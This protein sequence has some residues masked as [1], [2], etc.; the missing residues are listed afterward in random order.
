MSN[1]Q[2]TLAYSDAF[3][4]FLAHTDEKVVLLDVL[5][6]KIRV[7]GAASLLDIGAGNGDLSIPLSKIVGQY[8]ALEQKEDYVRRLKEAGLEV[9]HTTYPAQIAEHFDIVLFSHSLPS[10]RQEWESVLSAAWSQLNPDGHLI[11]V[12]FEDEESEWNDLV[13]TSG[14]E[15]VRERE[16]R[17]APLKGFLETLGVVDQQVITTHV[18]TESRED[19][20]RA[21][22][23]V[24]SDGLPANTEAFINNKKVSEFLENYWDGTHY[25][26]PFHHYLLDVHQ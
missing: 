11:L 8:V 7:L 20:V 21:L 26:F 2:T 4:V 12:T 1:H 5:S 22:A 24:W 15:L 23:F 3:Q 6:K 16:E 17:L 14:L 19:L 9:V 10:N 13:E 25:S 18:R